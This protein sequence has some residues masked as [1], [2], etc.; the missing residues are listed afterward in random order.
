VLAITK[1]LGRTTVGKEEEDDDDDDV[2]CTTDLL[3]RACF[4]ATSVGDHILHGL[5]PLRHLHS[6]TLFVHSIEFWIIGNHPVSHCTKARTMPSAA[7]KQ[8]VMIS[9]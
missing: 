1:L 3:L 6:Q 8:Q 4:E 7:E 5:F 2:E 9:S